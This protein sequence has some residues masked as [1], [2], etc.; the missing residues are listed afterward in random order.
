MIEGIG[1][2]VRSAWYLLYHNRN[3]LIEASAAA[4]QFLRIQHAWLKQRARNLPSVHIQLPGSAGC[5]SISYHQSRKQAAI[6]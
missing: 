3:R 5:T 1:S 6:E 4:V 2:K